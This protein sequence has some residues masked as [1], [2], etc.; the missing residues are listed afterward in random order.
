MVG[1]FVISLDCEGKWGMADT[2]GPQHDFITERK[3]EKVYER[4]IEV[5]A[6][7]EIEATFAF[8]GAFTLRP[9]DRAE[10]LTHMPDSSYEGKPWTRH[11]RQADRDGKTD[12]WFCPAALDMAIDA[13]HEIGSHGFSHIPFDD[14]ATPDVDLDTDVALAV[15]AASRRGLSPKTFVYPRNRVG[16][17]DIL[18]RH[19][20]VG[21]RAQPS[22]KGGR[23]GSLL[24]EI[25]V[26]TGA[27]PL[28]PAAPGDLSEIPSGYF[29][30]W[31][32][33]ARRLAPMAIS[34][35]R[36]RSI[37][38]SA[39]RTAGVAH[40]WFHPHNFLSGP[41]TERLLLGILADVA[42]LREAGDIEVVTMGGLL[43]TKTIRPEAAAPGWA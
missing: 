16:R 17:P 29:L 15:E 28:R 33:G 25:D 9:E 13:G 14:L 35:A 18:G 41:R 21:Y 24:S 23:L 1:R 38:R 10:F 7:Y 34:K 32:F 4:I 26:F 6:L 22:A 8:V 12:G 39:A 37:L 11:Y 43:E 27:Q 31:Q 19:G 3:L 40:L 42:K 36:W 5:F 20:F 30:N 2:I